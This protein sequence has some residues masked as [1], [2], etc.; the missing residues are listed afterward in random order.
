MAFAL[1]GSSADI[2][3]RDDSLIPDR[4]Y[5]T[6]HVAGA[7]WDV[8]LQYNIS[9]AQSLSPQIVHAMASVSAEPSR[10]V[11]EHELSSRSQLDPVAPAPPAP[12]DTDL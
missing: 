11:E 3:I 10:T 6:A 7:S 9:P 4:Y 2:V 12:A 8:I 5:P 1:L